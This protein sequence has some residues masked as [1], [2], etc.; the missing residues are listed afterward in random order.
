MKKRNHRGVKGV[1]AGKRKKLEAEASDPAFSLDL[2]VRALFAAGA[3]RK[4]IGKAIAKGGSL[5]T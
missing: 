1:T 2:L 4:D 3:N 5:T